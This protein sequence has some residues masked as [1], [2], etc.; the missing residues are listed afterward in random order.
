MTFAQGDLNGDGAVNGSD[1]A[2]LAGN[3]GRAVPAPEAP[4]VRALEAGRGTKP[5]AAPPPHTA[6]NAS[7][8]RPA[9]PARKVAVERRRLSPPRHRKT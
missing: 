9:T 8:R 2:I 1:F 3:F 7:S 6:D 4:A 5:A